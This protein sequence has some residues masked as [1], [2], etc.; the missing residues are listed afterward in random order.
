MPQWGKARVGTVLGSRDLL[1]GHLERP[2]AGW[3]W[4]GSP[5]WARSGGRHALS[6]GTFTGPAHMSCTAHRRPGLPGM[7][8]GYRARAEQGFTL[9]PPEA[10]QWAVREVPVWEEHRA[11]V[12][13]EQERVGSC[14]WLRMSRGQRPGGGEGWQT[15]KEGWE[16]CPGCFS[17]GGERQGQRGW[18]G[19]CAVG[20]SRDVAA[21]KV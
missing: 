9:G 3:E 10:S 8:P 12:G 21:Q 18:E 15:I 2:G 17:A 14:S 16:V 5:P 13:K 20:G 4:A 19:R 7:S 6:E 1:P 11:N